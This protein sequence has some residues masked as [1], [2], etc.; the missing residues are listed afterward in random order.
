MFSFLQSFAANKYAFIYL[1]AVIVA[2]LYWAVS[3]FT[4]F[5]LIAGGIVTISFFIKRLINQIVGD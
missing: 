5:L 4:A 1:N 2:M 3:D